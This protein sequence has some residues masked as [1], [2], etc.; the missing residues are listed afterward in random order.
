[1]DVAENQKPHTENN[2]KTIS[3]A[4]Q[5]AIASGTG[6]PWGLAKISYSEPLNN[7]IMNEYLYFEDGGKGVDVYVIDTG[8]NI[9]HEDFSGRA[10][11]GITTIPDHAGN[12]TFGRGT[13]CAG[14]SVGRKYGVAKE[15]HVYA[16]KVSEP[17][18]TGRGA[19]SDILN[20]IEWAVQA[21]VKKRK[22]GRKGFRGSVMNISLGTPNGSRAMDAAVNAAVDAGIYVAVAAGNDNDSA[23]N[24]SPA[25]AEKPITV[26]ASTLGHERA[27][28][29]NYGPCVD[30]FAPGFEVPGPWIG[31]TNATRI[32]SG[33]S[34]A[35]PHVAG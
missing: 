29:S 30:I 32:T 7:L 9:E 26:G 31:S 17:D 27:W 34:I 4:A 25:S 3:N 15:A 35:S 8:I 1:M 20:R 21:H 11:W 10:H 18:E 22:M 2:Q 24:L 12:N 5:R 13:H 23:C 14:I 28:F 33:T 19:L 6:A 16:I